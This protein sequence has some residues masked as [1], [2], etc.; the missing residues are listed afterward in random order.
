MGKRFTALLRLFGRSTEPSAQDLRQ[1]DSRVAGTLHPLPLP[2]LLQL[3]PSEREGGLQRVQ[4]RVEATLPQRAPRRPRN[5]WPLAVATVLSLVLLALSIWYRHQAW[6]DEQLLASSPTTSELTADVQL[7][8][9]GSGHASGPL[10][11]PH[12]DWNLGQLRVEVEEDRGVDLVVRTREAR[13]RVRGT[14]FEVIRDTLGTQVQVAQGSV[15]V[16][17][18]DSRGE[19]TRHALLGAGDATTCPP[20]SPSGLLGRARALQDAGERAAALT[21][22]QAGLASTSGADP[23]RGEL[24]VLQVELLFGQRRYHQA[25]AGLRTY[26]DE[27]HQ[28]RAEDVRLLQEAL[29]ARLEPQDTEEEGP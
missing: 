8:Y 9:T 4:R 14:S 1:L 22:V 15:A 25:L 23:I 20:T 21:A 12:I 26:L 19:R 24:L 17:C 11:A 6:L 18:L 28:A 16:S 5:Q 3:L 13:A 29:Q 10:D 2:K 27:G 7:A